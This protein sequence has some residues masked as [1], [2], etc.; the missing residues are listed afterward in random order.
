M[1]ETLSRD[2]RLSHQGEFDRVFQE[3]RKFG[4]S[5]AIIRAVP[6]GLKHS[7]L[8]MSLGRRV[9]NAVRRNR[10]KRLIREAY[11]L[12]KHV[13]G[14]PCDIV[15]VPRPGWRNLI[16]REIEPAVKKALARIHE[17]FVSG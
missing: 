4:A 13:L 3:G 14:C 5:F 2:E 9:G 12:N 6:N 1:K 10:I 8:G 11:R 17:T 16:L 15:V 7:R